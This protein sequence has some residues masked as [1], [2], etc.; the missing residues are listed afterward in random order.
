MKRLK[1][2][3]GSQICEI[4]QQLAVP[5][6]YFQHTQKS[7][8]IITN[9]V[10]REVVERLSVWCLGGFCNSVVSMCLP[11]SLSTADVTGYYV[12]ET[13]IAPARLGSKPGPFFQ[14]RGDLAGCIHEA[15]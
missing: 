15:N 2:R 3:K 7:G 6:K 12:S 11:A 5:D 8:E 1:E 9:K 10:T 13:N 14:K 4:D